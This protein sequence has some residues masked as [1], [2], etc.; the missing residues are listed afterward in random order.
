MMTTKTSATTRNGYEPSI[1]QPR[2]HDEPTVRN[3]DRYDHQRRILMIEIT[4]DGLNER[5]RVLADIIWAF[6]DRKGINAFIR[7]LPTVQLQDEAKAIVELMILA[8][9][10]QCYDGV[11]TMDAA[12]SVLSKYNTKKG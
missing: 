4:I 7:S 2:N 12:Q 9:V 8:A 1:D 5:Q 6:E 3:A 10:E 11:G